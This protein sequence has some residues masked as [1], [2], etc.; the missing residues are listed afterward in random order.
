MT[1][2]TRSTM[3]KNWIMRFSFCGWM[4]IFPF[5]V[6]AHPM[7]NLSVDQ[8][9]MIQITP[10]EIHIHQIVDM[11]EIPTLQESRRID[12]DKNGTLSDV[13][14]TA[15]AAAL[16]PQYLKKLILTLNGNTLPLR[17]EVRS[18][19]LQAGAANLHTLKIEWTFI[20]PVP[21]SEELQ[22][23]AFQNDNYA[24]RNGL[25]EIQV[26]RTQ[27]VEIFDGRTASTST[28]PQQAASTHL[29]LKG[30]KALFYYKITPSKLITTGAP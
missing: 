10:S 21:A 22:R 11:A 24:E 6:A 18:V 19:Q 4:G 7:G 30:R 5:C 26:T 13:E 8:Q 25:I 16:T 29:Q 28:V 14:L 27:G 20:A 23:I 15:Y 12:N 3:L 2:S 17:A 9:T 1:D